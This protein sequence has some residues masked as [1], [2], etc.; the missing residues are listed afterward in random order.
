LEIDLQID[1]K[2]IYFVPSRVIRLF[3][4]EKKEGI[5]DYGPIAFYLSASNK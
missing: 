5:L 4:F 3:L 2:E 1:W